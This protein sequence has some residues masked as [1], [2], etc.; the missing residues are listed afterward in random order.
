MQN[1]MYD[2]SAQPVENDPNMQMANIMKNNIV[3]RHYT[4]SDEGIGFLKL[5]WLFS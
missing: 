3:E 1:S 4:D 2:Q 5:S